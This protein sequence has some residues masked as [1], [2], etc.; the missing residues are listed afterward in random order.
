M[1]DKPSLGIYGKVSV[2]VEDKDGRLL[3][4]KEQ[5]MESFV[6]NFSRI[7]RGLFGSFA[8]LTSGTAGAA[9]YV[10]NE[11]VLTSVYDISNTKQDI[12]I[13]T[14]ISQS[15]QT[16]IGLLA[17][18]APANDDT[19]GIVIGGGSTPPAPDNYNLELKYTHGTGV[20]QFSYLATSFIDPTVS[21][22]NISF[23]IIRQFTN[24]YSADQVVR[25]TGI[26]ARWKFAVGYYSYDVKFLIVRD[27]LTSPVTVPSGGIL[28]VKYTITVSV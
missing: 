13:V 4:E 28:T 12:K 6:L 20:N 24:L 7:V 22:N 21:G 14:Y 26:I 3:Y 8:T 15:S 25:E 17:V 10:T 16:Q 27:V 5:P 1:K 2:R 23:S 9:I 11:S 18:N 19:W